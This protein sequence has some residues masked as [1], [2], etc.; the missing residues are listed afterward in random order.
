MQKL[1]QNMEAQMIGILIMMVM[2]IDDNS[3]GDD[4]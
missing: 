3:D 4:D 2:M 1:W